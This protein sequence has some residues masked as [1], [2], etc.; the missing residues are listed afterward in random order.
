MKKHN[1]SKADKKAA[2]A[3]RNARKSARGRKWVSA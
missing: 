1:L 2:K 3:S